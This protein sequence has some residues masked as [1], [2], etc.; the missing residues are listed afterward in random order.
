MNQTHILIAP[1]HRRVHWLIPLVI[2][3]A[4][5]VLVLALVLP[6]NN[7]DAPTV[8]ARRVRIAGFR[9][10]GPTRAVSPPRS[11]SPPS[12]CPTRPGLTRARSPH[13]SLPATRTRP[14]CRRS[15]ATPSSPGARAK[16][17]IGLRF[18]EVTHGNRSSPQSIVGQPERRFDSSAGTPNLSYRLARC[19]LTAAWVMTSS[20]AIARVDA[21]SVN[22]S[23]SSSGRHSATQ[24]VA[25]ARG[26]RR[27]RVLG[28]GLGAA[29]AQRVAEDQ[30]RL[31]DAGSRRRVRSRCDAQIRSPLTQV[32]FDEP[33]SVTHQPAGNRS[34]TACRRLAVG[35]SASAMSF[36]AALPTV[37]RS[38]SQLEAPAAHAEHHLDLR[39]HGR[40]LS[41]H[42]AE[43]GRRDGDADQGALRA[44][45]DARR[46]RR[47]ARRQGA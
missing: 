7:D 22:M 32:P 30:P 8:A 33:R 19:C 36:S 6:G 17:S 5:T 46:R 26:Q 21:G 29:G 47:G 15:S 42:A 35:S 44:A 16:D 18:A 13:R 2:V 4:A 20:S 40:S 11:L 10:P 12:P 41:T 9:R 25:L 34:S 1:P 27:R 23:R 24:H 43:C 31:A 14:R 38:A 3:V 45:R 37:V 39:R 28:L